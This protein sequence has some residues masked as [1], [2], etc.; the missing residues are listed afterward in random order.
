MLQREV[1]IS[2]FSE[3]DQT[4]LWQ[5]TMDAQNKNKHGL[6]Q[7]SALKQAAGSK[8]EGKRTII[9]DEGQDVGYR[10]APDPARKALSG[11]SWSMAK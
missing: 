7:G 8:W 1:H 6:G 5:N 11:R 9:E 10:M 3:Q 2:G 4:N